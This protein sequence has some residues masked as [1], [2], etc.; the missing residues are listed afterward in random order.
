MNLVDKAARYVTHASGSALAVLLS[1]GLIA[2]WIAG[3][4]AFGFSEQY[5]ILINTGTTIVTF[6]MVFMIQNSQNRD[7]AALQAKLDEIIAA[8]EGARNDMIGIEEKADET[9]IEDKRL[10][11]Q[12][13]DYEL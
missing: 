6:V 10:G 2:A 11:Y 1:I 3:G 8:T 5:Q 4:L 13:Y 9:Q 7:T 12:A